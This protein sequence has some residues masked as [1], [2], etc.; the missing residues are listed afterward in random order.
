LLYTNNAIQD[1]V[2]TRDD[3]ISATTQ[4]NIGKNLEYGLGINASFKITPHWQLNSDAAI[5]SRKI[6]S[7]LKVDRGNT[8]QKTSWRFNATNVFTFPRDYSLSFISQ[9]GSPSISY[10]P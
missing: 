4:D 8:Q 3:G 7:G 2:T 10:K 5:F 9:Y 6:S 1:V